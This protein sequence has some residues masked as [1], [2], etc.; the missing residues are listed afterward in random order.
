[1]SRAAPTNPPLTD[2]GATPRGL[3]EQQLAMLARLAEIGMEI[4]EAAGRRARVLADGDGA[5]AD[6]TDPGLSFARAARAVRLTLALQSRL[7]EGLTALDRAE[8]VARV[9]EAAR[10]R[11]RIH[12]RIE[13]AAE[14]ERIDAVEVERLSSDAWERL[15][16]EEDDDL[17]SRPIDEILALICRDLGLSPAFAASA[18]TATDPER[19]RDPPAPPSPTRPRVAGPPRPAATDR[20]LARPRAPPARAASRRD[21]RFDRGAAEPNP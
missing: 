3:I 19:V 1:M 21:P 14:A 20:G 16:D 17:L 12:R 13:E 18:F 15:T 4:A 6:A 10:R 2:L 11:H 5:G 8:A 9:G 7:T